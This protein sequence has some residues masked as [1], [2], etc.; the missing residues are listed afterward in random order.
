MTA[1]GQTDAEPP[2]EH[3]VRKLM[4]ACEQA[5]PHVTEADVIA[6]IDRL[7]STRS[8]RPK[9]KHGPRTYSWFVTVVPDQLRESRER[10]KSA[11]PERFLPSVPEPRLPPDTFEELTNVL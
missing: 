4:A 1:D 11:H 9:T 3:L 6:I 10:E 8:L 5:D 7:Y 2:S